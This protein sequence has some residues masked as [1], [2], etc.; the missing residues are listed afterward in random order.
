MHQNISEYHARIKL[1]DRGVKPFRIYQFSDTHLQAVAE[2][3]P[4]L[5]D[6][7]RLRPTPVLPSSSEQLLRSHLQRAQD[8]NADL[9]LNLGD[10]FHFPSR[11]NVELA[12]RLFAEVGIPV[13]SVPGNH[14]WFYPGMD[15]WEALRAAMMPRLAPLFPEG[16]SQWSRTWN[17][18]RVIGL[19]NSTYFLSAAQSAFLREELSRGEPTIVVLHIP[20]TT[21][22][23]RI[24]VIEKF[25]A[26]LLM[27]DADVE[28]DKLE[29]EGATPEPTA[30]ACRLL[31]A[32]TNVVAVLSAHVH[33]AHAA[34]V[35]AT[36][37]QYV[38]DAGY[39]NGYRLLEI[40]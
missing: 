27:N 4:E 20:V 34:Q 18:V 15:G 35:S 12:E 17:G 5:P 30:E 24:P 28:A 13:W 31:C 16:W 37:M 26:P 40:V 14:D 23:L 21:P 33:L 7:W 38:C 36:A 11:E 6:A 3:D 1:S 10:V 22:E 39:R 29:R 8:L 2:H 32:S 19:D 9:I 25:G